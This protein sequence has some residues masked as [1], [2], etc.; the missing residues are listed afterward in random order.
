[1]HS[2][3]SENDIYNIIYIVHVLVYRILFKKSVTI[4]TP[5]LLRA[6]VANYIYY[7]VY[8]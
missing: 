4:P 8:K 3:R 2:A 7:V 1:M 6:C 5:Y